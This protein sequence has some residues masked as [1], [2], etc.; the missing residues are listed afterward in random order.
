MSHFLLHKELNYIF[1]YTRM[2]QFPLLFTKFIHVILR[3]GFWH[4]TLSLHK[5]HINIRRMVLRQPVLSLALLFGL[6]SEN[7]T[8]TR[9]LVLCISESAGVWMQ[10]TVSEILVACWLC[11]PQ[12]ILQSKKMRFHWQNEPLYCQP[13]NP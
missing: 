2:L 5:T 13:P 10:Q 1:R 4:E 8:K 7:R 3:F 12:V 11:V 9:A 6:L